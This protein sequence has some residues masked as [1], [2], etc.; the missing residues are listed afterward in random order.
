MRI[1][2]HGLKNKVVKIQEPKRC[3]TLKIMNFDLPVLL[4]NST[5]VLQR[6]F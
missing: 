4:R 1:E 2:T 5:Q 3:L 6:R